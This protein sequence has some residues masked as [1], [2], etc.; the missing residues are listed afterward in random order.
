[1]GSGKGK[2]RSNLWKEH[3]WVDHMNL[4][5]ELN[6]TAVTWMNQKKN[7]NKDLVENNGQAPEYFLDFTSK[8][9]GE[10]KVKELRNKV[11]TAKQIMDF[12]LAFDSSEYIYLSV[13]DISNPYKD[14]NPYI[15]FRL[16]ST[17]YVLSAYVFWYCMPLAIRDE[18]KSEQSHFKNFETLFADYEYSR[19]VVT[20]RKKG[21]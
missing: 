6:Q 13:S 14:T 12:F 18:F 16:G 3:R 7:T 17:T 21:A 20:L 19:V 2:F 15:S 10:I 1:M 9:F 4:K 8:T 11:Y 5:K